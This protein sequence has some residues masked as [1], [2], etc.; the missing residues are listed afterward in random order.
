MI[1][2]QRSS[3]FR[4]NPITEFC[5]TILAIQYF[6][7]VLCQLLLQYLIA[8][9]CVYQIAVTC[10]VF[11]SFRIPKYIRY[12]FKISVNLFFFILTFSSRNFVN[13]FLPYSNQSIFIFKHF[14]S[15]KEICAEQSALFDLVTFTTDRAPFGTLLYLS[16]YEKKHTNLLY[17]KTLMS[18]LK[19]KV[20]VAPNYWV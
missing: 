9:M 7:L 10:S 3:F 6:C 11:I 12:V 17:Q 15:Q 13:E 5:T 8:S 19:V 14:L 4:G 20:L 2:I 18:E 1:Y 16:G